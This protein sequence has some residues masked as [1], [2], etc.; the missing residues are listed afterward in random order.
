AAGE[1]LRPRIGRDAEEPRVSEGHQPRVARE[2]VHA[3]SEDGIQ[4]DLARD[5][6]VEGPAHPPW[7]RHQQYER[8]G[9]GEPLHAAARPK[10]PCGRR[11]S[12]TSMGRNSTTYASSG[13]TACPKLKRNP[14][15]KLPTKDPRRFPPPPRITTT[16]ARGSISPSRPG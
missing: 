8:G 7:H 4:Q 5:V 2:H 15:I 16:S 11:T 12:T 14:T 10:S 3:E 1:D 6:D 9:D 13:N